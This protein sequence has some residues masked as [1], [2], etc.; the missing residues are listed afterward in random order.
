MLATQDDSDAIV[1]FFDC[2]LGAIILIRTQ[3]TFDGL[4]QLLNSG[5]G[6]DYLTIQRPVGIEEREILVVLGEQIVE[7]SAEPLLVGHQTSS[8]SNPHSSAR[9]VASAR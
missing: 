5:S 9:L 4:L 2:D 8:R 3:Q 6:L 1:H 7:A